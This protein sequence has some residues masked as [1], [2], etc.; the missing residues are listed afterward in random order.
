MEL[1]RFIQIA[2]YVLG[3]AGILFMLMPRMIM[4]LNALANRFIADLDKGIL[5]HERLIGFGM[6]IL[7]IFMLWLANA[8]K[9]N[10]FSGG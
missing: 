8:F 3:S 10:M 6:L 5:K 7:S 4:A 1:I 9:A 2:A